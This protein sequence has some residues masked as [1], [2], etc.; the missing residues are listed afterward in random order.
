MGVIS[1]QDK[2]EIAVRKYDNAALKI[3]FENAGA[4]LA[5]LWRRFL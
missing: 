5:S 3:N 2:S 4:P 1:G